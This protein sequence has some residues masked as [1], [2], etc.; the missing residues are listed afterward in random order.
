MPTITP[1]IIVRD[2]SRAA[3]WYAEALGAEAG[4]RVRVPDGRYTQIE[5][6]L[7]DSQL[8][9]ADEFPEMGAVS[10][11]T[12]GGTYGALTIAVEDA[13]AAWQRALDAGAEVFHELEDAFWGE[14]YGQFIDPFGHRWGVA[15]RQEEVEPEEVERRA[16]GLFGASVE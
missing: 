6:R 4:R 9:I 7:G 10:P 8:M 11:Q 13:D 5:L 15:Q 3:D 14:R 2:A 12:L 1:H 16:A